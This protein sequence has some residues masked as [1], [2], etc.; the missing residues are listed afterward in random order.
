MA[1]ERIHFVHFHVGHNFVGLGIIDVH[2]LLE[3]VKNELMSESGHLYT[4][5]RRFYA[6]QPSQ[7][8]VMCNMCIPF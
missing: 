3:D 8:I 2:I 4:Y 6:V 1:L 5:H 7:P